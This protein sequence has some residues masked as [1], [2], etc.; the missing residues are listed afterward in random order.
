LSNSAAAR[1]AAEQEET[2]SDAAEQEET[3]SKKNVQS[4]KKLTE[5]RGK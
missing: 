5:M 4:E 1:N 2:S 3:S